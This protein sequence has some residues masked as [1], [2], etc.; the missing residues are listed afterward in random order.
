LFELGVHSHPLF[1]GVYAFISL[2]VQ[3]KK[4][5]EPLEKANNLLQAK[6][7]PQSGSSAL[8]SKMARLDPGS[9][10]DVSTESGRM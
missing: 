3:W 2:S 5:E 1:F 4:K 9:E 7:V 6:I 10:D 8:Y